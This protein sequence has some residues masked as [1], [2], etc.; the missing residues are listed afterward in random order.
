MPMKHERACQT[1]PAIVNITSVFGDT[2]FPNLALYLTSKHAVIGLTRTV[3]LE[4]IPVGV[5]VNADEPGYIEV[6]M[7]TPPITNCPDNKIA[8]TDTIS[9]GRA[10]RSEKIAGAM[11]LPGR[12]P[13]DLPDR[14]DLVS[15]R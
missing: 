5:R 13:V 4:T 12:S 3:A 2:G 14:P 6:A 11:A 9:Q 10:E 7:L 8:A 15:R 1:E